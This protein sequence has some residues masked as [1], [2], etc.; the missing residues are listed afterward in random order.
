MPKLKHCVI[1]GRS[2]PWCSLHLQLNEGSR[3]INEVVLPVFT[4]HIHL[5]TRENF[6][7]P[8][9]FKGHSPF[10]LRDAASGSLTGRDMHHVQHPTLGWSLSSNPKRN[11]QDMVSHISRWGTVAKKTTN[12]QLHNWQTPHLSETQQWNDSWVTSPL[13]LY[14]DAGRKVLTLGTQNDLLAALNITSCSL[15][16]SL[17]GIKRG[18]KTIIFYL[19][20]GA[21]GNFV[22]VRKL[23]NCKPC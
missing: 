18:W 11:C 22:K 7:F 13:Q 23:P 10:S 1:K 4:R 21:N 12:E 17:Y 9:I 16:V 19:S 3:K 8:A 20:T 5:L 14:Q 2:L 6:W 15:S